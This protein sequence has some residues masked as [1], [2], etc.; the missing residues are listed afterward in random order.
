MIS[1]VNAVCVRDIDDDVAQYYSINK[2]SL[3]SAAIIARCRNLMRAAFSIASNFRRLE[4]SFQKNCDFEKKRQVFA[5]CKALEQHGVIVSPSAAG[6][7]YP[8]KIF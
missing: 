1:S 7:G 3:T 2:Q 6:S 5:D 8:L 4:S